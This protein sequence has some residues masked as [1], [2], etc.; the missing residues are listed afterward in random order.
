MDFAFTLGATEGPIYISY[1]ITRGNFELLVSQTVV[2]E[3]NT[4]V[5]VR[6]SCT[7]SVYTP[8]TRL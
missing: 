7:N 2:Q 6:I 5:K 4:L 1:R 8:V 3:L